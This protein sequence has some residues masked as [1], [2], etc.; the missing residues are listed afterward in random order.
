MAM[1]NSYVSLPEGTVFHHQIPVR[2]LLRGSKNGSCGSHRP[3]TSIPKRAE[4]RRLSGAEG[5]NETLSIS[6]YK[7][8]HYHMIILS[9]VVYGAVCLNS[10][11]MSARM[12]ACC[13]VCICAYLRM[14]VRIY[15]CPACL[16][17]CPACLSVCLFVGTHRW[18]AGWMDGWMSVCMR[19]SIWNMFACV[20]FLYVCVY[21]CIKY[22]IWA[23]YN[24]VK[25]S[26]LQCRINQQPLFFIYGWLLQ[27]LTL[28]ILRTHQSLE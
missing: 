21:R 14:Y 25:S 27:Y 8:S 2:L 22:Q 23:F 12:Y 3:P 15:V 20:Y 26:F 6:I 11:S 24:E 4:K 1:F 7:L 5:S 16:P 28:G 10:V 9:Y 18:L 19:A 17:A 13:I